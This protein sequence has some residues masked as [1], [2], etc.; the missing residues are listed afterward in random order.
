MRSTFSSFLSFLFV[1]FLATAEAAN[2]VFGAY[3]TPGCEA[4]LDAAFSSCPG[5]Y[6][7]RDYAECMFS[8]KGGAQA[9]SCSTQQCDFTIN[10]DTEV[11]IALFT[12]C[13][14]VLKEVCPSFRDFLPQSVYERHCASTAASVSSTASAASA[15]SASSTTA[16]ATT[17]GLPSSNAPT[18]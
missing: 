15:S 8:G 17:S 13:V 18:T 7:T 4:C 10:E 1:Y 5:D 3:V 11:R 16:T 9:I 14:T 6:R 2:P 12:Y